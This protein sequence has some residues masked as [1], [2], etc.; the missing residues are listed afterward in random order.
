MGF[1]ALT[2]GGQTKVGSN[3]SARLTWGHTWGPP[4]MALQTQRAVGDLPGQQAPSSIV[5]L[6]GIGAEGLPLASSHSGHTLGSASQPC[7]FCHVFWGKAMGMDVHR[8]CFAR[9]SP[10]NGP[11]AAGMHRHRGWSCIFIVEGATM[12]KAIQGWHIGWQKFLCGYVKLSNGAELELLRSPVQGWVV[13][14][15]FRQTL[16][17]QKKC[18]DEQRFTG[19]PWDLFRFYKHPSEIFKPVTSQHMMT[20]EHILRCQFHRFIPSLLWQL[21]K[22]LFS[23]MSVAPFHTVMHRVIQETGGPVS[24]GDA[25]L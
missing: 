2:L 19:T 25:V 8:H 12:E 23:F 1:E 4:P 17:K 21:S 18:K 14:A 3:S 11:G 9:Y 13:L 15:G 6:Q 10:A 24:D 20:Q 22:S 5:G 16:R 7:V